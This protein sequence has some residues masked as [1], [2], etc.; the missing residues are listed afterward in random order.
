MASYTNPSASL[1]HRTGP[2]GMYALGNR[3]LSNT[4]NGTGMGPSLSG[5][6]ADSVAPQSPDPFSANPTAASAQAIRRFSAPMNAPMS[7]PQVMPPQNHAPLGTYQNPYF[8]NAPAAQIDPSGYNPVTHQMGSG[9]GPQTLPGS[10]A[11]QDPSWTDPSKTPIMYNFAT[12]A[13]A[14]QQAAGAPQSQM[15]AWNGQP[16]NPSTFFNSAGQDLRT[17]DQVTAMM[18][19]H[20]PGSMWEAT[21][22]PTPVYNPANGPQAQTAPYD[23]AKGNTDPSATPPMPMQMTVGQ[24]FVNPYGNGGTA[25]NPTGAPAS[26]QPLAPAAQA[27]AAAPAAAAPTDPGM[28]GGPPNPRRPAPPLGGQASYGSFGGGLGQF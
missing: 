6:L 20:G 12:N 5:S 8:P 2:G 26:G 4:S 13:S 21:H 9:Q 15:G 25:L 19:N 18:N 27:P 10:T 28:V 3:G 14:A 22:Q 16:I 23:Y 1:L 24:D 11:Q 7:A 17:P